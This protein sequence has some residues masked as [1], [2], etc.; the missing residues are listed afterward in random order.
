MRAGRLL[1][2]F[3]PIYSERTWDT[4]DARTSH[5]KQPIMYVVTVDG[6]YPTMSNY[7]SDTLSCGNRLLARQKS[8]RGRYELTS[9]CYNSTA[10]QT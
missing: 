7:D 8:S 5:N 3:Q 2:Y 9:Q 6:R 1:K 4:F 10:P